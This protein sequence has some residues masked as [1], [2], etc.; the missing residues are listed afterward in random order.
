[1]AFTT[2]TDNALLGHLLGS[3]TYAKP[4]PYVALFVGNPAAGGVEVSTSGTG[5]ARLATAF[6]V[7]NGTATNSANLQWSAA[8]TAWGTITHAA[9]YDAAS[10]GNQLMTAQL[11]VS[12]TI[13]VGDII[14]FLLSNLSITL[15]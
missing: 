15:T 1:M 13:G 6:T 8:T 12:K 11:S 7:S 10:G 14:E 9:I 4:S 5:Y 2:Y 3:T